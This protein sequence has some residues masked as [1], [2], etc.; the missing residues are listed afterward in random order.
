MAGGSTWNP[1][2]YLRFAAYRARPAED[3]MAALPDAD[4]K[5]V[6]SEFFLTV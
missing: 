1:D 4:W 5:E 2:V 6:T 3:L